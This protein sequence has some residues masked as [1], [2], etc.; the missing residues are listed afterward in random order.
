MHVE[1]TYLLLKIKEEL[2]FEQ[3]IGFQKLDSSSKKL[4]CRLNKLVYS[5]KQAS[6]IWYKE[7]ANFLI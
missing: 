1:L 5:L 4:I 7:L 6:K 3:L 2:F